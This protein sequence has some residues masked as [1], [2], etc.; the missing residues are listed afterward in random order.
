MS[1]LESLFGKS[2]PPP[3]PSK[4]KKPKYLSEEMA[5]LRY[6]PPQ[7]R[8]EVLPERGASGVTTW[9]AFPRL[10]SSATSW[11]GDDADFPF[12]DPLR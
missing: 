10:A 9:D 12:Y 8:E 3:P 5:A 2:S 6:R 4:P 1:W 11:E 7:E